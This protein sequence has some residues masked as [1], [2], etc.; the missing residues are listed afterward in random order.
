M[1]LFSSGFDA[2]ISALVRAGET[3]G[4]QAAIF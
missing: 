1:E 4:N 3:T 2:V